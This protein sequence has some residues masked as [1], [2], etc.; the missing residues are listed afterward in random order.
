MERYTSTTHRIIMAADSP[1]GGHTDLVKILKSLEPTFMLDGN[2]PGEYVFST[3]EGGK[4]GAHPEA[5]PIACFLEVEG[6]TLVTTKEK[7]DACGLSYTTTFR[8]ITMDVHSSLEAIGLTAVLSKAMADEKISCNVIAAFFHDHV[9]VP[10]ADS[11]RAMQHLI[12]LRERAHVV[13]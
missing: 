5:E 7:A 13:F 3:I 11:E 6:L 4:Y 1:Q 10:V 2:S 9:F 12:E 8:C